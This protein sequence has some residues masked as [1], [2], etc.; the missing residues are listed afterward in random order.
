EKVR[1]ELMDCLSLIEAGMDFSGEDI[2]F[3]DADEAAKRLD[4][5][6]GQLRR[7]LNGSISYEAVVDLPAVGIA[8]APNAGKSSLLNKLL[9]KERSIVSAQR[10]TTRDVLTGKM[11]L[12]S[13]EC[14]L[15]DCAGLILEPQ[16]I[17][18]ELA[19]TAAIEAI[20]NAAV[21]LFCVDASKDTWAEDSAIRRLIRSDAL[22]AAATKADLVA[23]DKIDNRLGDLK[24]LFGF[25]FSAISSVKGDGIDVLKKR[26][27]TLLIKTSTVGDKAGSSEASHGVALT[28]RH[29]QVVTRAAGHISEA[30]VE[31]RNGNEE[32]AAML[33]RA[34]YQELGGIEH[35]NVDERILENIFSRFCIGK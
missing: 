18:D 1:V 9:G 30:A 26:I 4:G 20:G 15:F 17:I 5:M 32:V 2:E 23:K 13:C 27:E 14:V 29:K 28:V 33:I 31:L 6:S 7:L 16:T 10:K 19:Q 34:A 22:I 24:E 21:I 25:D 3:I 8:G 12:D 11:S 35:E